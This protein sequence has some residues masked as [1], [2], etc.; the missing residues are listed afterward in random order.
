MPSLLISTITVALIASG[1]L[2]DSLPTCNTSMPG[3]T[4]YICAVGYD[5]SKGGDCICPPGTFCRSAS[6]TCQLPDPYNNGVCAFPYNADP[7]ESW[8]CG[9]NAPTMC[10]NGACLTCAQINAQGG[11]TSACPLPPKPTTPPTNPPTPINQ[12]CIMTDLPTAF[13]WPDANCHMCG[14]FQSCEC[15]NPT[16]AGCAIP[17][18]APL[19]QQ[20]SDWGKRITQTPWGCNSCGANSFC[21][22]NKKRCRDCAF[23]QKNLCSLLPFGGCSCGAGNGCGSDGA[24]APCSTLSCDAKNGC[25]VAPRFCYAGANA[26]DLSC[27]SCSDLDPLKSGFL[28]YCKCPPGSVTNTLKGDNSC[29]PA[30]TF[31]DYQKKDNSCSACSAMNP[32]ADGFTF[33]GCT[34]PSGYGANSTGACIACNSESAC[35][36][37]PVGCACASPNQ[38]LNIDNSSIKSCQSCSTI[39]QQDGACEKRANECPCPKGTM[40]RKIGSSTVCR[41]PCDGR[42]TQGSTFCDINSWNCVSCSSI[43]CKAFQMNTQPGVLG[44]KCGAQQTCAASKDSNNVEIP[45]SSRCT[46]CAAFQDCRSPPN[47]VDCPGTAVCQSTS[48][49]NRDTGSC[50]ACSSQ[51]DNTSPTCFNTTM[52]SA[53]RC[54]CATAVKAGT[55]CIKKDTTYS[56]EDCATF[57]SLNRCDVAPPGCGCPADKPICSQDDGQCK[58]VNTTNCKIETWPTRTPA[59]G[60]NLSPNVTMTCSVA[61]KGAAPVC[62]KTSG[63][64]STCA[65]LLADNC[66]NAVAQGCPGCATGSYCSS[67]KCTSCGAYA[68]STDGWN[69]DCSAAQVGTQSQCT[70]EIMSKTNSSFTSRFRC[71]PGPDAGGCLTCEKAMN[72]SCRTG[73]AKCNCSIAYGAGW[74]CDRDDNRCRKCSEWMAV[75]CQ[76]ATKAGCFCLAGTAC[77]QPLGASFSTYSNVD[78]PQMY[79][80]CVPC[81][82]L[83]CNYPRPEG[84]CALQGCNNVI[85][86]F[87]DMGSVWGRCK[88]CTQ[89]LDYANLK[90]QNC[91]SL[92]LGCPTCNLDA[93]DTVVQLMNPIDSAFSTAFSA[94]DDYIDYHFYISVPPAIYFEPKFN[95]SLEFIKSDNRS[96]KWFQPKPFNVSAPSAISTTKF[97]FYLRELLTGLK[98][99]DAENGQY[100]LVVY[101]R[102]DSAGTTQRFASPAFA[103]TVPGGSEP[104]W[105]KAAKKYG[106]VA[107]PVII[108]V[109]LIA[110]GVWY[111]TKG[112]KSGDSSRADDGHSDVSFQK[113]DARFGEPLT[114]AM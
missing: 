47:Q 83:P 94:K 22:N 76:A 97:R 54:T 20:D 82:Q 59:A 101:A 114:D 90:E 61:T 93:K 84:E 69:T 64:C 68:G 14:D 112:S 9:C 48:I 30:N 16:A 6:S 60:D 105:K 63:K 104:A 85:G 7:A 19:N 79:K 103:L 36:K 74:V 89:M 46:N 53:R 55:F 15:N 2:A 50:V 45:F 65:D 99:A 24:C 39:L 96:P 37:A 57:L 111:V 17:N 51:V 34:C 102:V 75:D 98:N 91:N 41:A 87:C 71:L 110:V 4:G 43:D 58:A 73:D 25:C 72:T 78:L 66:N 40:C 21:D 113:F 29:C 31:P 13:A 23:A 26:S 52:D 92:P 32:Y 28:N 27:K 109:I 33:S 88:S 108:G 67:G 86:E 95:V 81:A 5:L 44:C 11:N 107:A 106:W 38:C 62:D 49:C 12:K 56:C 80:Q 35:Q 8:M 42:C 18:S 10:Y 100:S 77:L 1:V 3:N 70:C